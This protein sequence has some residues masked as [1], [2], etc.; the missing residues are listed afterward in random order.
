MTNKGTKE[1]EEKHPAEAKYLLSVDG[2][3]CYLKAIT[4]VVTEKALGLMMPIGGE[5][6]LITAGEVILNSCWL[7]GDEEIRKNE[8]LLVEACLQCVELIE[9][10]K[11]TIKKL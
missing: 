7:E 11:G 10:K 8:E 6:R 3:K 9:R 2:K 4:R 1:V 5:P